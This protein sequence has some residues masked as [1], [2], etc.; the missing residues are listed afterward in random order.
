LDLEFQDALKESLKAILITMVEE[1]LSSLPSDQVFAE[2]LGLGERIKQSKEALR[3]LE[4][5]FIPKKVDSLLSVLD[6][7]EFKTPQDV[8][9][10][11][12]KMDEAISNYLETLNAEI[13]TKL[14]EYE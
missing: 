6:K 3:K 2:G 4:E 5:D 8:L 12:K 14:R 1:I 11:R 9:A 13:Q 10:N 7:K